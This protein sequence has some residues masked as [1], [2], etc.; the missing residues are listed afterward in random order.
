MEKKPDVKSGRRVHRDCLAA[1]STPQNMEENS[2]KVEPE[3]KK[4]GKTRA[5]PRFRIGLG[6]AVALLLVTCAVAAG[7]LMMYFRGKCGN[8]RFTIKASVNGQT[9]TEEVEVDR[10]NGLVTYRD[11]VSTED[12]EIIQTKEGLSVL[13][14]RGNCYLLEDREDNQTSGFDIEEAEDAMEA[15]AEDDDVPSLDVDQIVFLNRSVPVSSEDDVILRPQLPPVCRDA[16]LY[17]VQEENARDYLGQEIDDGERMETPH[18]RVRR[19]FAEVCPEGGGIRFRFVYVGRCFRRWSWR[20]RSWS[21]SYE[22]Q[23]ETTFVET[24]VVEP[25]G[26]KTG[27]TRAQPRFRI[28][29]GLAVALLLVTCAVAAG[30]LMMYFRG[31]CGNKRFTI[32]GS[33]NGQ[34]FTEEVEVDRVNGLVT[35][36]DDVSTEDGEVIQTREG[37]TVLYHQGSCYVLENENDNQTSDIDAIEDV[38]ESLED[39]GEVPSFDVEQIVFLNRSVPVSSEDDVLLRPQLPPVC[40]DATLYRVQE[41]NARG[42]IIGNK[43]WTVEK[44]RRRPTIAVLGDILD[45]EIKTRSLP[46]ALPATSGF[47][48]D[49]DQK[50]SKMADP[51]TDL[52]VLFLV[53]FLLFVLVLSVTSAVVL[54]GWMGVKKKDETDEES[55]WEVENDIND[56]AAENDTNTIISIVKNIEG[57]ADVTENKDG[58]S[59]DDTAA[60]AEVENS[61]QSA[62]INRVTV[63]QFPVTQTSISQSERSISSKSS[64]AGSSVEPE[65]ELD[66]G[67][68]LG[69]PPTPEV[70][71]ESEGGDGKEN[72]S[73][74]EYEEDDLVFEIPEELRFSRYQYLFKRGDFDSSD[75]DRGYM[76]SEDELDRWVRRRSDEYRAAPGRDERHR[77]TPIPSAENE[78]VAE[79]LKE[80]DIGDGADGDEHLPFANDIDDEVVTILAAISEWSQNGDK[81]T[82]PNTATTTSFSTTKAATDES[83]SPSTALTESSLEKKEGNI[84]DTGWMSRSPS[85]RPGVSRQ[86]AVFSADKTVSKEKSNNQQDEGSTKIAVAEIPAFEQSETRKPTSP[87]A[88]FIHISQARASGIDKEQSNGIGTQ[89]NSAPENKPTHRLSP[90]AQQAFKKDSNMQALP[91]IAEPKSLA[92]HLFEPESSDEDEDDDFLLSYTGRQLSTPTPVFDRKSPDVSVNRSPSPSNSRGVGTANKL[93]VDTSGGISNFKGPSTNNEKMEQQKTLLGEQEQRARVSRFKEMLKPSVSVTKEQPKEDVNQEKTKKRS[94]RSFPR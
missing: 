64:D 82:Q 55:D 76:S 28:G 58:V 33:V 46:R 31:K 90:I 20:Q 57:T 9:F 41:E 30:G 34:T 71:E 48:E 89:L 44:V 93:S 22:S 42:E 72:L 45:V 32:K 87:I 60:K 56:E 78:D 15:L 51:V 74:E 10:V 92:Q 19:S 84:D 35:Y 36:R 25:D 39:S 8:K 3:G 52:F 18:G 49:L 68:L 79:D 63:L 16:T 4:T 6:L 75:E 83:G 38:M 77:L 69:P 86:Q 37:L 1:M 26:K 61:D 27:K 14:E 88:S 94:L 12:G 5:Q 24:S 11:D 65:V 50:K 66:Y 73:L 62:S 67:D 43:R 7:G 81:K 13:Y 47:F 53:L 17:R 54:I 21:C 70:E 59:E 40:R 23:S 91:Q 80:E 85:P 2:K 29:L